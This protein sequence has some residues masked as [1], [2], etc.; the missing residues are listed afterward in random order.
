MS[1]I[2]SVLSSIG[3]DGQQNFVPPAQAQPR[4]TPQVTQSNA[5]GR[6]KIIA[7]QLEGPN[8]GQKRKAEDTLPTPTTKLFKDEQGQKKSNGTA[9]GTTSLAA[10]QVMRPSISTSRTALAVPYRG[11]SRPGPTSASPR[12]PTAD[13]S[14]PVPKKGSYA[15]IM[16]R[17][18]ANNKPSV[19]M[20]KHKPKE[21]I[22]AKKEIQM[23]KKGLLPTVAGSMKDG[24]NPGSSKD[25]KGLLPSSASLKGPGLPGQN[26]PQPSYKGTA[27]PKPKPQ[28]AYKGTMKPKSCIADTARRKDPRSDRSR[29]NS[30]NPARRRKD[31]ESEDDEDDDE[32]EDEVDLVGDDEEGI[33]SDDMEAGF[34]DVEEEE[35]AATMAARKEDE[36][37]LKLENQ[38]KR[39]KEERKRK[40]AAMAAKAAKP[41]F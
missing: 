31:Y 20:I 13:A 35:T 21:A 11:T 1:F 9:S 28:P 16:A 8:P 40:L 32:D 22:S 29:S 4:P 39:E 27:A 10:K 6:P 24:R 5:I 15:E 3:G 18:T 14:K 19:G 34:S 26:A 38:L 23:R 12:T 2:N 7:N 17:A 25:R 37:E 41:R 33:E 36:R 30:M